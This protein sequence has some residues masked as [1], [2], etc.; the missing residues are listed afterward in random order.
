MLIA[1]IHIKPHNYLKLDIMSSLYIHHIFLH[2]IHLYIKQKKIIRFK[3]GAWVLRV[4][5]FSKW[6]DQKFLSL[7]VISLGA[8]LKKKTKNCKQVFFFLI[9]IHTVIIFGCNY[10]LKESD[11][12][13]DL[14]I[15]LKQNTKITRHNS[16][17]F[18]PPLPHNLTVSMCTCAHIHTPRSF[19]PTK[20]KKKSLPKSQPPLCSQNRSALQHTWQIKR[21]NFWIPNPLEYKNATIVQHVHPLTRL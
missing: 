2:S 18:S 1:C 17:T 13:G 15:K 16:S 19:P 5:C 10:T 20:S 7:P 11:T 9:I 4:N 6:L 14:S 8:F 3:N 21:F 12:V